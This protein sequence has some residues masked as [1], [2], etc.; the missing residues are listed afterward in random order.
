MIKKSK[1]SIFY[2]ERFRSLLATYKVRRIALF[3]S[4]VTGE[5][6][7]RSDIDFLVEFKEGA[8]LF[9]QV[10]LK[11]ELS[12]LLKKEVDV[13][14]PKALSRYIRNNVLEKAVYLS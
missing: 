7:K 4:Y 2:S 9:D 14:T 11:L 1:N 5:N 3:G 13:T 8:D 10:G 6:T 12:K